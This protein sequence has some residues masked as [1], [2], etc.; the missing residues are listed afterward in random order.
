MKAKTTMLDSMEKIAK[1]VSLVAIPAA[2]W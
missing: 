1:I 2:L